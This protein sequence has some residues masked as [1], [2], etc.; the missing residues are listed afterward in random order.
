MQPGRRG[1]ALARSEADTAGEPEEPPG[2]MAEGTER[3]ARQRMHRNDSTV[4][5]GE[6][7]GQRE[8][9]GRAGLREAR[10]ARQ[11][12]GEQSGRQ[13][14]ELP[15]ALTTAAPPCLPGA[16]LAPAPLA[17]APVCSVSFQDF[18]LLT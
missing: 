7:A 14:R 16:P 13:E 4:A 3:R 5:P 17:L 6:S 9:Q 15:R 11:E 8:Q 12:A 2:E 10:G 1:P 18:E